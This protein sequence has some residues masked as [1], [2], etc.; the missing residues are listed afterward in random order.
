[1]RFYDSPS[2]ERIGFDFY[3]D[4][5][6]NIVKLREENGF[7]QKD[8]AVKTG[9]KEYR[10]SN[11]ENVKIRI[12]LD[13]VEE[14]A[15]ALNVSADYLIDAELDCGGKECLYQVWL[16]SEDRFKLYIRASSKRM[17]FLKFDKKF[18]E[19]G[20]RYNSSRERIFIKLVGVPVSKEDF[21]AINDDLNYLSLKCGF[22]TER[23][24]FDGAGAKTA[25]EIIS[26]NSDMYRMLK[27][28]ET[29]LEDVLKRL[30]RIIIRLGIVTG[31]TLDQNTDIVIDFDDSIIE[32]KGAERQ[33]DRQDV[34]MGVMRH[35]EYRAKWYGETVEQAKK[36]LPEQNQVME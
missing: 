18:K 31:N 13:A 4:I 11:M 3:C 16:E 30:I 2:I 32:D 29:I 23:Y 12:D 6:N 10:I 24:R 27:K 15:K 21:Q 7:T 14:L 28:H 8:L 19:C 25:T 9:I 20:V 26:E 34:S 33:Q 5:A 35:E 17:A 36:N 1:M 22:G